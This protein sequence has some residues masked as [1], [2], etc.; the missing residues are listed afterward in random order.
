MRRYNRLIDKGWVPLVADKHSINGVYWT[1]VLMGK[2][3]KRKIVR[4]DGYWDLS[5]LKG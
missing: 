5:A 2:D 3:G 1:N 4:L